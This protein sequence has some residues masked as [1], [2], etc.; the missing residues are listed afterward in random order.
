MTNTQI[1]GGTQIR[2]GTITTT[3]LSSSA[4][5]TDGQLATSYIKSDGTR[6]FSGAVS[7]GNNLINNVTDPVSAQDA[8][9]K[10]YVD[11]VAQGLSSKH[12]AR[13]ATTGSETFTI[14]S[15]NVTQITGTSVDGVSPSVGDYILIKDAPSATGTGSANST[16]P[17]NGLYSV[18]SNTTNLSVSRVA[19]LS[20]SI[21]PGGAY[22]FVE[23]GTANGSAGYVVSNPGANSAFTYGTTSMAWTQFTGAGEVT[24]GNVLTKSGNQLSV[25]SMATGTVIAGNAGTPTVTTL[26]GD[27]TIGATGTVTIANSAVSLAKQANLA[28]NSVI[29]NS[30]GS[31]ATPTA[32]SMLSTATASAVAI[33]D[34]NA[35]VRFN[36][37]IENFQAI[38]SAAGTTTLTVGSPR[39]TQV[40]GSTTQI[41]KL[42]DATTLVVGQAFRVMNR[43]TGVVTVNDNASGLV[44]SMAAGTFLDV[45]VTAI[46]TAAGSWDVSYT[47]AGGGG[48]VTAVSVASANGFAGSSS[49]GT[50]PALTIS[51][52]ITGV[53]KGN[54]TAISAATAGTD[55]M[56]PSDFIV[57]ETP[58]GTVNG[59]NTAFTLANTPL[60]GTE[61]VFLN[62]MLQEPG[63]G[64]DY[65]ISG[66][67]ITYLSAPASGD[68]IRVSY[69]K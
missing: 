18:T 44:Q 8:A 34:S 57:R 3:Q 67:S 20:G 33:R 26:G 66:T 5:I 13:V 25:A 41:I 43:S 58:S 21:K 4:A 53:L 2:S 32:V 55:Y 50:T 35:N 16:Q 37:A 42:P 59:S 30:T 54:G 22:V 12:S 7:M 65:T 14:S 40:T 11:T 6:A 29:G 48:T 36:N 38:T 9:T 1:N 27:V 10:N 61:Q 60:S 15:G 69:Y 45:V 24:T 51:T 62:G 31:S 68:R 39:V 23:A 19:E 49:G 47:A 64:N 63:A 17:G 28:A 46:G 52:S 56:A